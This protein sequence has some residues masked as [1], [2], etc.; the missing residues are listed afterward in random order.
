MGKLEGKVALITGAARGQGRS[1]A[2]L[3]ASEGADIIGLD[4]CRQF[5]TV[6][7]PMSTPADLDETVARVEGHDRRMIALQGDVRDATAVQ[8][9]VSAAIDNF[10]RLDIVCANAG[11]MAHGLPPYDHSE[12]AWE[13]SLATMLTGVWNVLRLSAPVLIESG[14]GG[15]IV[16]TSS[17]AGLRGSWTTFDGGFDGYT[18]AKWGVVGLMRN[19]AAR[20]APHNI[21]VNTVHPTGVATGMVVNDFFP[22]FMQAHPDVAGRSQ[23]ALPVPILEPIDISRAILYLVSEDGRYVT[24]TTHVIDAGQTTVSGPGGTPLDASPGH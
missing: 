11:I 14:R 12:A 6:S 7:Y 22:A 16:I 2:E 23:N 17:T 15:A 3:L 20:L 4:V 9:A 8:R 19:Y 21:R 13:D 1:H 18:A 24:G 5:E 10:G